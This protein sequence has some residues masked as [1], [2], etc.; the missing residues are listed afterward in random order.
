MSKLTKRM[1][2]K[3]MKVATRSKA[4]GKY[5]Q[6]LLRISEKLGDT[7]WQIHEDQELIEGLLADDWGKVAGYDLATL[8]GELDKLERGTDKI[9]EALFEIYFSVDPSQS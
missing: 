2:E 6:S 3:V 1:C 9:Q 7:R 4:G 5:S 8:K